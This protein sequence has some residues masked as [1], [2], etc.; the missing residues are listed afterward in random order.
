MPLS[1]A[2]IVGLEAAK[3]ALLLLA[4][5]PALAGV[6][7]AAPVG[8]GK[9]TL[10]RAFAAL[11]PSG[12]PFVELPVG[13]TEE[14]VLGGLDLEATLAIGR[15]VVA[16][17]LL[18]RAH[19]G[20]LYADGLNLLDNSIV[21]HLISA[22]SDGIV[23]VER[24]GLSEAHPARFLLVGTYD[25]A[26]GEVPRSLLDRLGLIVPFAP[27]SDERVRAAVVRQN[28]AGERADD[29]EIAILQAMLAEARARL[30]KVQIEEDQIQALIQAALSLGVEGNRADAFAVQA[31]L[32]KAAF[33]GRDAVDDDDLKLAMRLVLLPRA[34]QVP[35]QDPPAQ[36]AQH[37]PGQQ[38]SQAGDQE[39]NEGQG[40]RLE[41]ILLEAARVDLPA[42]LLDLP[43]VAQRRGRSGSRGATLNAKR[44]RFVRAVAG[45]L[46]G[47]RIALLPTLV[48]A[49]P[50]QRL[51]QAKHGGARLEIRREDIRVKRFRD[52]AGVLYIFVVDAS[53]SMAI[54]RMRE[55]KGAVVRLLQ[56]AYVHRDQVGLI[57]FRG[58]Q[59]QVLLAPSQSVERAKRA[60]D[61]LPTGG[62]TP[63][64][65][66]LLAAWDMAQQARARGISQVTLVLMTDGR[67]N[68]PLRTGSDSPAAQPARAQLQAELQQLAAL[69]RAEGIGAVVIDTQ[70]NY[71]SRGEASRLAAWLGGR[72]V[73]LP[74]AKAE[75]IATTVARG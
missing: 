9:S 2:T 57:A 23:R 31:A 15:R 21:A 62:G 4:V 67:G 60:L 73:Y 7:I 25:P 3:Q 59:A 17:G 52:K 16:R 69:I 70:V 49:A 27:Q 13:A 8:S 34:T 61:V 50:W 20:V 37:A 19:G 51:R 41:D 38:D 68:V 58:Q 71:L 44:G 65:S 32:A 54:N 39:T 45:D 43:F 74:N 33:D 64:A 22:L 28:L 72:Y 11:L 6:A 10:A 1:F 48:A 24:D 12:T 75:Q 5:N 53:G 66:A 30:T 18:A 42:G 26:E 46:R 36:D 29:E 35:A 55:A 56:D 40:P 47:N 14:S 63:L